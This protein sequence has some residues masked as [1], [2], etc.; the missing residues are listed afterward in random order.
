MRLDTLDS[1]REAIALYK[2]LGFRPIEPYYDNPSGRALF[3]ELDLDK[4]AAQAMN[5]TL[6]GSP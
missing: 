2:S 4:S 3:M 1:M 5:P 6:R